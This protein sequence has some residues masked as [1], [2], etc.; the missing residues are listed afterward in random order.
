MCMSADHFAG[1]A[2]MVRSH[3]Q[4]IAT[5]SHIAC[6]A[7]AETTIVVLGAHL[8]LSGEEAQRVG[9]CTPWLRHVTDK[10]PHCDS[11]DVIA[12]PKDVRSASSP[13]H[14]LNACCV[15][16]V[17]S[18]WSE[19]CAVLNPRGSHLRSSHVDTSLTTI[20]QLC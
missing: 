16:S 14:P 4:W 6:H 11:S 3:D 5:N 12:A 2:R 8:T 17:H 15:N 9:S 13:C 19:T 10:D 1:P 20:S 7:R 18:I